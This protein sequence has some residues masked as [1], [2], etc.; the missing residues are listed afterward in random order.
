VI[1]RRCSWRRR[2]AG[3]RRAVP[4][5]LAV[6]AVTGCGAGAERA[7]SASA[8]PLPT[9][10][11]QLE[12]LVVTTVP[13][14]LPRMPDD[15]LRPRAGEK[16]LSDVASYA[17]NPSRERRVLQG[18]GYR[19]GWE[20]FWGRG[21]AETSV[22]VDQFRRPSGARTFAADLARND[23]SHYRAT[24]H[25]GTGGLPGGC[26]LLT[27]ASPE[28]DT[29]LDGPAAFAWCS[30]G[31]FSVAVTAVSG[32]PAAALREVSAVVRAQLAGLG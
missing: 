29:G 12:K 31:V 14:G 25:A 11:D 23:A 18:Y 10:A 1:G 26:R 30:R 9:S 6:L 17:G 22:F 21:R 32:T 28:T 8:S 15:E 24:P 7:A 13:S 5:L 19:F 3:L 16:N 27:V 2:A 20:R 4:A